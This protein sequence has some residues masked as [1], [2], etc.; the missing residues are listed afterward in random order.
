VS[1]GGSIEKRKSP[2]VDQGVPVKLCGDDGDFVTETVNISAT[3]V[4][5][6]VDR[7]IEPMTRFKVTLLVPVKK[8]GKP[9]VKKVACNG[10]VVRVENIP[11]QNAF[12]VAIF[13]NEINSSDS[14][15][16]TE[17]V[18]SVLA[19]KEVMECI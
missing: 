18:N 7:Y 11:F 10:A 14:R 15:V 2:R 8:G 9:G 17:H 4:Y 1:R 16:L 19:G 12:N 13:F 6:R 5:C 3:G